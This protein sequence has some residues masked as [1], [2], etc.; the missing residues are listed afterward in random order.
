M[1]KIFPRKLLL[2][3]CLLA[4]IHGASVSAATIAAPLPNAPGTFDAP[5]SVVSSL[6]PTLTWS[7]VTGADYYALAISKYPYGSSNIVYNPQ[8]I[9]GTSI[10]VPTNTLESGEK[11]R[12]N[13][14]AHN[15][16]GWSP[17][18]STLYFATPVTTANQI[19]VSL[20][21]HEGDTYGAVLPGMLITGQD[22]NGVFFSKT[23]DSAGAI[24]LSGAPGT[25]QFSASKDGYAPSSWSTYIA[26]S[27]TLHGYLRKSPTPTQTPSFVQVTLYM[28]D[29]ST[30]GSTLSG[31]LITGQ[32]GN[33]VSFSKTTD[34]TGAIS[35]SGAPGTWQFSVSKEGYASS[36]WSNY[37][38][39]SKTLQGYLRKLPITTVTTQN[40]IQLTICIHETRSDGPVLSG[41]IIK[42]VDGAG[43]PFERVTDNTGTAVISGS[44]GIWSF[45]GSKE[46]YVPGTWGN[47]A[48]TTRRHDAYL[49][50]NSVTTTQTTANG[51]TIE[52][53]LYMHDGSISG[54]ALSD[55]SISGSD[56]NGVP[57]SKTTDNSGA[58]TISGAPGKWQFAAAKTGYDSTTWSN[59]LTSSKSLNGHLIKKTDVK[60][61]QQS[62]VTENSAA[63]KPAQCIGIHQYISKDEMARYALD[64]GFDKENAIKIVAIAWAES[65][66]DI[67]ACPSNAENGVIKSWDRGV[68]QINTFY[69]NPVDRNYI[70]SDEQAFDPA[71]AFKGAHK[72]VNGKT[73]GATRGFYEWSSYEST[74]Y[75]QALSGAREAVESIQSAYTITFSTNPWNTGSLSFGDTTYTSGQIGKYSPKIY[76]I[77]A[78]VPVG[79]QF[80]KWSTTGGISVSNLD[81]LSTTATVSGDGSLAAE[82]EQTRLEQGSVV[83]ASLDGTSSGSGSSQVS[84]A[85]QQKSE[86]IDSIQLVVPSLTQDNNPWSI[87]KLGYNVEEKYNIGSYGCALT[88]A[89]MILNYYQISIDPGE[90]NDALKENSGFSKETLGDIIWE[91]VPDIKGAESVTLLYNSQNEYESQPANLDKINSYLKMGYPVIAKVYSKK[92][93]NDHWVV[94]KGYATTTGSTVYTINDPLS[95]STL[96]G[97]QTQIPNT[98]YQIYTTDGGAE[99]TIKKI[100]VYKGPTTNTLPKQTEQ[101]QSSSIQSGVTDKEMEST[102]WFS[103]L[104]SYIF[105]N[106][107]KPQTTEF[108]TK[109]SNENNPMVNSPSTTEALTTSKLPDSQSPSSTPSGIQSSSV[110]SY[111]PLGKPF[112]ISPGTGYMPGEKIYTNTPTLVWKATDHAEFYSLSIRRSPYREENTVYSK[113]NIE[114]ASFTVPENL[115]NRGDNYCWNIYAYNSAGKSEISETLYFNVNS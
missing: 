50:K 97:A 17:I 30:S 91:K 110:K 16:A 51:N 106:S 18:S 1:P 76:G 107:D 111:L 66:G 81:S 6:T 77:S 87:K 4:V 73:T 95:D 42:G 67:F 19:Q 36:S 84:S 45:S 5:G 99:G 80:K 26:I 58:I 68:L 79:Y 2:L 40:S 93:Q 24:S 41:V 52:V 22:G 8:K 38:S 108:A 105:P 88:S 27:K 72:I 43:L 61:A 102:N 47:N 10:T 75:Y 85:G 86:K 20:I 74:N 56:G 63:E 25:W 3:L 9:Y 62:P 78:T 114:S 14:Q 49:Q 35:L 54:S 33:G 12:W 57:F 53:L 90:L 96:G 113:E 82:F 44:P 92:M 37:I 55:I 21:M 64:A 70:I 59:Y 48:Y 13:M 94:I 11:Y 28:H 15:S 69:R 115:L 89:A 39:I 112:L 98:V 32:D 71:E 31:V 103:T 104:F 60:Q 23:T 83:S 100:V 29:G 101:S 65:T 109:A 7:E 46:G 34:S